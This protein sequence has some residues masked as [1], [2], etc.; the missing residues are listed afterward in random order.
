MGRRKG[1]P[2]LTMLMIR[3]EL[4]DDEFDQSLTAL[5]DTSDRSAAIVASALVEHGLEVAIGAS[6]ENA[7]NLSGLFQGPS[8]PIGTFS[9]RILIA[10]ALGCI[11]A[12]VEQDLRIIKEVRNSFAHALMRISFKTPELAATC[13]KIRTY[14]E[15]T[16]AKPEW[17]SDARWR[18]H[19]ACYE[20]YVLLLEEANRRL[21][22]K[23]DRRVRED[24]AHALAEWT[25]PP[26][27]LFGLAGPLGA[28]ST[29]AKDGAPDRGGTAEA[30]STVV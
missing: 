23:L 8:A 22:A 2:S 5:F 3:R 26:A 30:A 10:R 25:A 20:I 29:A 16:Q 19:R 13:E 15:R 17:F 14:Q 24:L 6:L 28:D 21:E 11:S 9:A 27:G 12:E 18:Y 1:K 7:D 4:S